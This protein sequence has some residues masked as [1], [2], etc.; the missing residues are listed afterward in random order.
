MSRS[1]KKVPGWTQGGN[2]H[3]CAKRLANKQIRKTLDIPD[4][5]AFRKVFETWNICDYRELHFERRLRFETYIK[6]WASWSTHSWQLLMA[7]AYM[8]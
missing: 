7:R 5:G 3:K 1:R 6:Q 2:Y 8:K 4:G